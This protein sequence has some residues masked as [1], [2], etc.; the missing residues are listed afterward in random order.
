MKTIVSTP[1]RARRLGNLMLLPAV[2]F[3]AFG[4]LAVVGSASIAVVLVLLLPV[5]CYLVLGSRMRRVRV[6]ATP[7]A[8]VVHNLFRSIVIPFADVQK[9]G[10]DVRLGGSGWK[11]LFIAPRD[12]ADVWV[13]CTSCG[14]KSFVRG[15]AMMTDAQLADAHQQVQRAVDAASTS[16]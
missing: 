1:A 16:T 12:D 2:V 4:L 13:Y 15:D 10:V 5:P 9:V 3:G 6:D 7:N 11:T 14:P 8:L